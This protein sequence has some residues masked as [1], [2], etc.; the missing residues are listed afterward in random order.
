MSSFYNSGLH[1]YS[2]FFR[3][4]ARVCCTSGTAWEEHTDDALKQMVTVTV[5]ST[6]G[7]LTWLLFS[8]LKLLLLP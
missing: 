8:G 2:P 4:D 3:K 1:C 5:K 6:Q 7:D